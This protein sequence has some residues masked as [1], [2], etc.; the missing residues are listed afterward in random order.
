MMRGGAWA[1]WPLVNALCSEE[2]TKAMESTEAAWGALLASQL[3]VETADLDRISRSNKRQVDRVCDSLVQLIKGHQHQ[4]PLIERALAGN[5]LAILGDPRPGVGVVTVN[6]IE[7]PDIELCYVPPGPFWM[8]SSD[9]EPNAD[10]NEKPLHLVDLEYGYW[11][12]RYPVTVGQ[13]RTFI[14]QSDYGMRGKFLRRAE[15]NP[16]TWPACFVTV[17]DALA[18]CNWLADKAK[19]AGWLP[20]E[21][22]I[23]L[24]SEAEWEK[25][26]RGG[27]MVPE[28][29]AV[30]QLADGL[31]EPPI[32]MVDN[33]AHQRSY[34]MGKTL[35]PHQA[36]YEAAGIKSPSA[37]GIFPHDVGPYGTMDLAG[38]VFDLTRSNYEPYPYESK[39]G[40][41]DLE[42]RGSIK[43]VRGGAYFTDDKRWPR[44]SYRHRGMPYFGGNVIGFRVCVVLSFPLASDASEL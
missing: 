29:A 7:L 25:S 20:E 39:D 10:D 37:V 8:G 4:L 32:K 28:P 3:M 40:R 21:A 14:S 24:P 16:A 18:F 30:V 6:A 19:T 42:S 15:D 2:P 23:T 22:I 38:N 27:L 34:P 13:F 1:L 31:N 11:I 5:N 17:D 9:D 43:V 44:S 33:P 35:R 41:E 26:A 12:G 36:N